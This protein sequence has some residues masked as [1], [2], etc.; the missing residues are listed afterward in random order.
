V[1]SELTCRSCAART[2]EGAF[3]EKIKGSKTGDARCSEGGRGGDW[4]DARQDR[5]EDWPRKARAETSAGAKGDR[6]KEFR[7]ARIRQEK[8]GREKDTVEVVPSQEQV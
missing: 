8:S 6:E 4:G 1:P 3:N 7:E 5:G 2:K